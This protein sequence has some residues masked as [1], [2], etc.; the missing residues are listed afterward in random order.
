MISAETLNADTISDLKASH[1]VAYPGGAR[2]THGYAEG[3]V[4]EET[5]EEGGEEMVVEEQMQGDENIQEVVEEQIVEM[6]EEQQ[7][8]QQQMQYVDDNVE[9]ASEAVSGEGLVVPNIDVSNLQPGQ[10]VIL[11]DG[12]EYVVHLLQGTEEKGESENVA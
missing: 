5:V 1:G 12:R 6:D 11:E 8:L 9:F 4:I 7:Q 3:Q 2:M 10:R